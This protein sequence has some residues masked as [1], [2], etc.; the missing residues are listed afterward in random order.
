M[1]VDE[2]RTREQLLKDLEAA[3]LRLR[4]LE[5]SDT[6]H[7]RAADALTKSEQRYRSL[8]ESMLNGFAVHEVVLD[9]AGQP[10]DYVFLE[11]NAAFEGHTGLR[12]QDIVGKRVTEVLPGNCLNFYVTI[13]QIEHGERITFFE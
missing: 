5:M 4:Q 7:G 6:D 12:R 8:F 10:V 11:V 13:N 3:E 2:G 9:E 1:G